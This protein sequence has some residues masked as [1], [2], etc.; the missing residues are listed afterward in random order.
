MLDIVCDE[1]STNKCY[2]IV[3]SDKE[4]NIY[5]IRAK[6]TVL[7]CGGLGGLYK[8]ST[9]FRH[10]TGDALAIAYKHNIKMKNIHY[11]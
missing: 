9:N 5:A 3:V 8:H 1:N 11:I 7:A 2:G 4:N 6:Y 10:I